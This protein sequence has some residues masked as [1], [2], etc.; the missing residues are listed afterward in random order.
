MRF[1]LV[2]LTLTAAL[3]QTAPDPSAL[4]ERVEDRYNS[5]KTLKADFTLTFKERGRAHLP[6]TGTL[7]LSKPKRTRW[8]YTNP[9]GNFFLS[10]T[11]YTYNYDKSKNVVEREAFRETEDMRIPLAFLIGQLNFKK[12]FERFESKPE[13]SDLLIAMTPRNK[14]L[15]FK[16]IRLL[17]SPDAVI[18]RA[19]VIAR[20]GSEQEYVLANEQR[21]PTLPDSTF[22]FT[23]PPG[24]QV[25]DVQ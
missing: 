4:L 3:A 9:S 23:A 13:G 21:N 10:D 24:A 8:D 6:E 17:V 1:P 22:K 18:K 14:K 12:D 5:I 2:L 7:Y 20:D 25:F 15:L 16:E 19:T 11:K